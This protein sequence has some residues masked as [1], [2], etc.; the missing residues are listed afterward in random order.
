MEKM[1]NLNNTVVIQLKDA[2]IYDIITSFDEEHIHEEA[3]CYTCGSYDYDTIIGYVNIVSTE[4]IK[5]IDFFEYDGYNLEYYITQA[6]LNKLLL[7]DIVLN[8][9]KEVSL[10]DFYVWIK[11]KLET[12]QYIKEKEFYESNY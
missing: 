1:A 8:D 11:D 10:E 6:D 9:L 5:K 2:G 12:A 4:G 3:G 7:D